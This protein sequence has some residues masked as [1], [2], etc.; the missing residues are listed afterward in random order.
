M[1]TGKLWISAAAIA[2]MTTPALAQEGGLGDAVE[3][4]G[5]GLSDGLGDNAVGNAVDSVTEG[6]DDAVDDVGDAL[7]GADDGGGGLGDGVDDALGGGNLGGAVDDVVDGTGDALNGGTGGSGSGGGSGGSGG[8]GSGSGGTGSGAGGSGSSGG[9]NTP[10][11]SSGGTDDDSRSSGNMDWNPG[12]PTAAGAG[13]RNASLTCYNGGNTTAF[14]GMPVVSSG[15]QRI[16][17]VHDALLAGDGSI[18]RVRFM[19]R[20]ISS[21]STNCV[22]IGGG[23]I[24]ASGGV[25]RIPVSTERIRQSS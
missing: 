21:G 23:G 7:N 5:D 4:V 8:S 18:G 22:E 14:T 16:G 9:A 11:S 20:A 13:T 24:S 25:V 19:T 12:S 1:R 6:A 10:G 2:L 15:G 17:V 3:D